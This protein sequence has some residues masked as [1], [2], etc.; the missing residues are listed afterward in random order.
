MSLCRRL[1]VINVGV[2]KSMKK[3]K[4]IENGKEYGMTCWR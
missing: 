4:K 2:L 3:L 1:R